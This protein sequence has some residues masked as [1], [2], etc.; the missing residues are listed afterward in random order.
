MRW[1]LLSVVILWACSLYSA[2]ADN[3]GVKKMKMQFATGPLLKFQ[4]CFV[5]KLSYGCEV[6]FM[7][8]CAESRASA[9][10]HPMFCV[11]LTAPLGDAPPTD[12]GAGPMATTVAI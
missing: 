11:L 12:T 5:V 2:S 10:A 6:T 4:I 7:K 1:L 3:N 9:S 8:V